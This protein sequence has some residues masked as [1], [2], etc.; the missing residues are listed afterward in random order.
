MEKSE[1]LPRYLFSEL[2]LKDIRRMYLKNRRQDSIVFFH[3][4]LDPNRY[5][6]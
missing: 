2:T 3:F 5:L 6:L 4:F 1:S